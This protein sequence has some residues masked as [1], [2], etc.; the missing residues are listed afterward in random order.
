MTTD[1]LELYKKRRAES[2]E[3]SDPL[4][5]TRQTDFDSVFPLRMHHLTLS[6]ESPETLQ[7]VSELIY[8]HFASYSGNPPVSVRQLEWSSTRGPGRRQYD[9]EYR[10]VLGSDLD[11]TFPTAKEL[12]KTIANSLLPSNEFAVA[13]IKEGAKTS[14]SFGGLGMDIDPSATSY[15]QNL[16]KSVDPNIPATF[17][18]LCPD[19]RDETRYLRQFL[20]KGYRMTV[21]TNYVNMERLQFYFQTLPQDSTESDLDELEQLEV[22]EDSAKDYQSLTAIHHPDYAGDGSGE[23]FFPLETGAY[24][25]GLSSLEPEEGGQMY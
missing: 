14:P 15:Q 18:H 10:T 23:Y 19:Y 21:R 12:S 1:E 9:R 24:E 17:V 6:D 11:L 7:G 20:E 3:Q 22:Q 2:V 8:R 4:N 13:N 16:E 5:P 25:G